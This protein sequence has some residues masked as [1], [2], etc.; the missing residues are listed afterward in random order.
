LFYIQKIS[1]LLIYS[2]WHRHG[3]GLFSIYSTPRID[4][5]AIFARKSL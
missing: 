1:R 5:R 4:G 3:S 2:S